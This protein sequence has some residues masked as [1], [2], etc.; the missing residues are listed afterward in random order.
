[1]KKDNLIRCIFWGS[2]L[3]ICLLL[4]AIGVVSYYNGY[5]EIGKIRYK[6]EPIVK[7]FNNN[8]ELIRYKDVGINIYA[9][10]K[11]NKITVIYSSDSKKLTYDFFY[12]NTNNRNI[13]TSN[14]DINNNDESSIIMK[15]MIDSVSCTL[16]ENEG[17]VFNRYNL[18]DF[19][20]TSINDGVLITEE[21]NIKNIY[22][23]MDKSILNSK[24]ESNTKEKTITCNITQNNNNENINMEHTVK[25][26]NELIIS[27]SSLMT[28]SNEQTAIQY[29]G[30]SKL[31]NSNI[32]NNDE[33]VSFECS[34]NQIKI[35]DNNNSLEVSINNE[36]KE[37]I[38][39]F[40][41]EFLKLMEESNYTCK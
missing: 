37:I 22:I 11:K 8:N 4:S 27:A 3:L 28:F 18:D 13:L 7:Q 15:F 38:G 39:L 36:K 9:K 21:N 25:I 12:E 1:M 19:Y 5:G 33:K 10:N 26:K 17:E 23:N 31:E 35:Q 32:E 20:N 34:G 30:T 29:C 16:G 2:L 24:I 14:F 6:L 40:E 41:N